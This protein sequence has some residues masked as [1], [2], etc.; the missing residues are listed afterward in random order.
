MAA[1]GGCLQGRHEIIRH[2][3]SLGLGIDG[4]A[5]NQFTGSIKVNHPR[6]VVTGEGLGIQVVPNKVSVLA[7]TKAIR[8]LPGCPV[9]GKAV[10][11]LNL[12]L[13]AGVGLL[14]QKVTLLRL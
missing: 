10:E 2:V 4:G 13:Q 1:E 8:I 5:I 9:I 6:Q 7:L 12:E 14:C 3:H 11:R